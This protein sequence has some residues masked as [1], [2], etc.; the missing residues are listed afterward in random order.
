M[1]LEGRTFAFSQTNPRNSWFGSTLWQENENYL[2][3]RN[4]KTRPFS[5]NK[6]S[7]NQNITWNINRIPSRV[8]TATGVQEQKYPLS[9]ILCTS[10]CTSRIVNAELAL[11]AFKAANAS[12]S[13]SFL[14]SSSPSFVL[15]K[16]SLIRTRSSAFRLTEWP[17][18]CCTV[19]V[20]ST[21]WVDSLGLVRDKEAQQSR[22]ELSPR[23]VSTFSSLDSDQLNWVDWI[24]DNEIGEDFPIISWVT[25]LS[26]W[27]GK[28]GRRT[29]RGG[30]VW[31][32]FSDWSIWFSELR[33]FER[34][35][36]KV[37]E[38][39]WRLVSKECCSLGDGEWI[40]IED[41]EKRTS[42]LWQCIVNRTREWNWGN[43]K[44]EE[45]LKR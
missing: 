4:I 28:L 41:E 2:H 15:T 36:T 3:P 27:V 20:P 31:R 1:N 24:R 26:I 14:S 18:C 11:Q 40:L 43:V 30:G 13:K 45:E 44:E 12:I 17:F 16:T 34:W 21:D 5:S 38:Q 19:S 22:G 35:E 29:E 8:S 37:L 23:I 32:F 9:I 6:K 33:V 42:S 39:D 25:E 7:N 10:S